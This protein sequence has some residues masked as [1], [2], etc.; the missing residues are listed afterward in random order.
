ML[1]RMPPGYVPGLDLVGRVVRSA[2]DGSGPAVGARVMAM[3][4]QRG[5]GWGALSP[6]ASDQ[7]AVLPDSLADRTAAALP[8]AGM[9]ALRA[10]AWGGDLAGKRVLVTGATGGVGW[11]ACQLAQAAGAIVS[12]T[13]SN[14]SR[15][16]AIAPLGLAAVYVGGTVTGN[17]ELIVE[18]VGGAAL[19][20]AMRVV[21]PDGVVTTLG[22]QEGFD[23]PDTPATIPHGWFVLAPGAQ[24][25]ALNV[26]HEVAR[27]R[28]AATDLSRLATL[29]ASGA[30]DPGIGEVVHW[31]QLREIVQRFQKGLVH[32]K[33]VAVRP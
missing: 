3:T 27:L 2:A 15:L 29:A 31:G 26:T 25:V 19:S 33:A 6:I 8:T 7:V 20:E 9:T 11:L 10:L 1:D 24:L 23:A 16:P 4:G 22:G 13:V 12:G 18:T 21:A 32:G 30:L 5:G 14:V 17:Y 28:T